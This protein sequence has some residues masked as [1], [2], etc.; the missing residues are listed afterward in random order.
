[1]ATPPSTNVHQ[2]IMEASA[3]AHTQP[4]PMWHRKAASLSVRQKCYV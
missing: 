2:E 1:M 4:N 3:N